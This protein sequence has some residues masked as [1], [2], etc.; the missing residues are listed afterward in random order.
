M[1]MRPNTSNTRPSYDAYADEVLAQMVAQGATRRDALKVV[2]VDIE[3]HEARGTG[4]IGWCADEG[5]DAYACAS[6][7]I[8]GCL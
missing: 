6:G 2:R 4:V 3:A 1:N 5:I 7:L 8:E